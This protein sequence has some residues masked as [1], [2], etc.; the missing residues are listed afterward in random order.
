MIGRLKGTVDGVG[1]DHVI[2]D[3][4]GVG[5]LVHCSTRTLQRLPK[6]GE[7]ARLAIETV[8]REDMI[9]LYGFR[10]DAEREWFRSM[11]LVQGVGARVAL[12]ILSVLDPDELARAVSAGDKAA[13]ARAPGVGP[14]LAQRIVSEMKDKAPGFGTGDAGLA[15]LAGG[16]DKGPPAAASDAISALV[17]LGYAQVQAAS[18]IARAVEQAGADAQTPT[19]IRLGLKEL[20]R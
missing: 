20:A 16:S 19:L 12:G 9:R 6:E 14:K 13:L 7:A 18:A 11:Q 3:V 4:H 17:N 5:Y 10:T 8:V 15:A 1:E 2:L